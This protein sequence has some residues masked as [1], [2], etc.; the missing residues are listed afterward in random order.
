MIGGAINPGPLCSEPPLFGKPPV[1]LA[2]LADQ[3]SSSRS[4]RS[5]RIS[6]RIVAVRRQNGGAEGILGP[7]RFLARAG[8]P[9]P[10]L[11]DPR[12]RTSLR[13]AA[14]GVVSAAASASVGLYKIQLMWHYTQM[15]VGV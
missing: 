13:K 8:R 6:D 11:T 14:V 10:R 5:Q 2:V 12:G 9:G 4:S 7:R 3:T 15:S 1:F